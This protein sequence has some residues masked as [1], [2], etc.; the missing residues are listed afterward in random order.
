MSTLLVGML[1]QRPGESC[2]IL[3]SLY[4]SRTVLCRSRPVSPRPTGISSC[5]PPGGEGG[6]TKVYL[7]GM[8]A[9]AA[10]TSLW[11]AGEPAE[12]L[13]SAARSPLVAAY[14]AVGKVGNITVASDATGATRAAVSWLLGL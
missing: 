6:A 2:G 9:L 5:L 13:K 8:L 10:P 4:R 11:V 12:L 14:R 1:P 7:A 3:S